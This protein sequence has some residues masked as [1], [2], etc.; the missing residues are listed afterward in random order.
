VDY[1]VEKL[2]RGKDET[3]ADKGPPVAGLEL[4]FSGSIPEGEKVAEWRIW[5]SS[6]R[7]H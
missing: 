6:E 1:L 3:V 4:F 5:R 7:P 2:V